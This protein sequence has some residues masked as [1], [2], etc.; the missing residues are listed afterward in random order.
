MTTGQLTRWTASETGGLNPETLSEP[1]LIRWTTIDGKR[2]PAS[3]TSRAKSSPASARSSSTSMAG[4]EGQSR[5]G[6]LGRN[7]YFINELG[8]AI[9]YPNVR[10][11]SGYGKT[12]LKLDNGTRGS[13][14]KD[15]GTLL[16]WIKTAR[17][18]RDRVMVTGGSYGGHMT[19]APPP[20][21]ATAS[22]ASSEVSASPTSCHSSS[23]PRLTA[24][25]CAGS[26]TA[27]SA[28]RRSA[29][30]W[31]RSPPA[32]NNAEHHEPLF[33][34]QG[35]NDPRV[36]ATEA[37]RW[38]PPSAPNGAGTVYMLGKDEGHGFAKRRTATS[39]SIR[40]FSSCGSN[41]LADK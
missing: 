34:V 13:S 5:P 30:S 21:T 23:T 15:I 3:S 20:T 2:S 37:S 8:V 4:P 16:D 6:F 19:F 26:S 24:A 36:P 41:L 17:P 40:R 38:S 14:Y 27:T 32:S 18:R 10:G 33:V 11:S 28:T 12:F 31:K 25:T 9:I 29:S 7:N 39:S 22:A 1:E 35:A